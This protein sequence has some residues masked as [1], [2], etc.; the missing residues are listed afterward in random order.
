MRHQ[1]LVWWKN[2]NP[3]P[4]W[5]GDVRKWFRLSPELLW[6]RVN[7]RCV[8]IL[9]WSGAHL[10]LWVLMEPLQHAPHCPQL[11]FFFYT[12]VITL[13]RYC[14]FNFLNSFWYSTFR[15][16]IAVYFGFTL[17]VRTDISLKFIYIKQNNR[18]QAWTRSRVKIIPKVLF[19]FVDDFGCPKAKTFDDVEWLYGTQVNTLLVVCFDKQWSLNKPF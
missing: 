13:V 10:P 14:E 7:S 2:K 12:V 8:E 17:L 19:T 11:H 5:L 16:K 15:S 4:F 3:R 6:V 18:K 9:D 1:V